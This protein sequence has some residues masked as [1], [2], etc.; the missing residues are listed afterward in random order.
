MI[1]ISGTRFRLRSPLYLILV[2]W[3]S[4]WSSKQLESA[5]GILDSKFLREANWSVFW[6]VTAWQNESCRCSSAGYALAIPNV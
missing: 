6:S 3:H 5:D 4:H 1:F 2:G